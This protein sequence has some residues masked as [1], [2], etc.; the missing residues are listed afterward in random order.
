MAYSVISACRRPVLVGDAR[1]RPVGRSGPV[2]V[3]HGII[4][5]AVLPALGDPV[6]EKSD[7]GGGGDDGNERDG[8]PLHRW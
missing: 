4:E 8:V 7:E 2:A 1:Q 6:D 5:R 3:G